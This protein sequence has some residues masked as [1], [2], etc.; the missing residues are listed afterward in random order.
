MVR[1]APTR[2]PSNLVD[3]STRGTVLL[4]AILAHTPATLPF[5]LALLID[6]STSNPWQLQTRDNVYKNFDGVKPEDI[7][8][9]F[10]CSRRKRMTRGYDGGLIALHLLR[11]S[12]RCIPYLIWSRELLTSS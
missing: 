10:Q 12:D 8:N 2:K 5:A 3:G 6:K 11:Y 7:Q 9:A 1:Q 4:H